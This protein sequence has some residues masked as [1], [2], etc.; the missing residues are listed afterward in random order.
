MEK[1]FKKVTGEYVNIVNHTIE[2]LNKWPNLQIHI[3][4][5]S[6]SMSNVTRYATTIVYRYGLRGAHYIVFKEEVSRERVEYT[7]LYNEGIRTYEAWEILT[8]E[9]PSI[10]PILEFDYNDVKKTQ[11][12][13]LVQAFRGYPN[14]VFKSGKMIAAKAADHEC[15]MGNNMFVLEIALKEAA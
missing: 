5:D 11:S 15:R 13:S 8:K 2:Q 10:S 6:Q 4:T 12:S 7:R 14:A 3:A 1:Y 9:I